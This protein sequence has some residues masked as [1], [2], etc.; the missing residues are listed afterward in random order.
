MSISL[1]LKYLNMDA[2]QNFEMISFTIKVPLFL[3]LITVLIIYY[4]L[5]LNINNYYGVINLAYGKRNQLSS[6]NNTSSPNIQDIQAA[7]LDS[8]PC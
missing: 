5:I 3:V 1:F 4:N 7:K 8:C 6:N 2:F